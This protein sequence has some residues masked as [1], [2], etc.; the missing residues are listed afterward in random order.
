M[1][2]I[3]AGYAD[4]M[5]DMLDNANPGL[6]R[7]FPAPQ[8]RYEFEN[9]GQDECRLVVC[10]EAR[11]KGLRVDFAA[12]EM[13]AGYLVN[14]AMMRNFGNAGDCGTF[15]ES[16]QDFVKKR[17]AKEARGRIQVVTS[18][19]VQQMI[20]A[21]HRADPKNSFPLPPELQEYVEV[22]KADR[23]KRT[24][25]RLPPADLQH[26]LLFADPGTGKTTC[27]RKLASELCLAGVL[28]KEEPVVVGAESL[29]AGYIGQTGG[30]ITKILQEAQGGLLFIDEA[31]RLMPTSVGD[32]KSE[33]LGTLLAAVGSAESPFAG[34]LL[35]M[36]AGYEKGLLGLM[37]A[38]PGLSRR[39]SKRV[40]IAPV[41]AERC[42]AAVLDKIADNASRMSGG[43]DL[44]V[45]WLDDVAPSILTFF[46]E[47]ITLANFG[48]LG[49]VDTFV[50]SLHNEG[51]KRTMAAGSFEDWDGLP[52]KDDVHSVCELLISQARTAHAAA[53]E[54][55][56]SRE[57]AKRLLGDGPRAAS[58]SAS[59]SAPAAKD[60]ATRTATATRG[61][62]Q[63]QEGET[64]AQGHE[65]DTEAKTKKAREAAFK[66]FRDYDNDVPGVFTDLL[67]GNCPEDLERLKQQFMESTK[68][69]GLDDNSLNGVFDAFMTGQRRA[70]A[71]CRAMTQQQEALSA[72]QST[73]LADSE[74]SSAVRREV[75]TRRL[76]MREIHEQTRWCGI[77]G[78]RDEAG[79]G[80][81]FGGASI[82]PEFKTET[83]VVH[84]YT[85]R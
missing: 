16:L 30:K 62:E 21:E 36:L 9:F 54:L 82:A 52:S 19:V 55:R 49:E 5:K 20:D 50:V 63:Q 7:R 85:Q 4:E 22:L 65:M 31:P 38:D 51:V 33:I 47:R 78:K 68:G 76:T 72:S 6:A 15:V 2:V 45:A 18:D 29:Q 57:V 70:L 58:S 48:N 61:A 8:C 26:I 46:E 79:S 32:F 74:A 75:N 43:A 77:C 83:K 84:A 81:G 67:D 69:V 25:K 34:K 53:E 1:A 14:K 37:T 64:E 39:F 10:T 17:E 28:A 66:L 23:K 44:G 73:A 13:C 60:R 41:T 27:A 35:I 71:E 56:A 40:R 59:S 24:A 12:A 80:C 3:M 11:S 42:Q